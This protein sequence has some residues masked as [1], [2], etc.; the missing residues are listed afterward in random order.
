[1]TPRLFI[2]RSLFLKVILEFLRTVSIGRIDRF[3]GYFNSLS[4]AL[5]MKLRVR[6]VNDKITYA[7]EVSEH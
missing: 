6:T 7:A 2:G 4:N 1:M 5:E 3:I